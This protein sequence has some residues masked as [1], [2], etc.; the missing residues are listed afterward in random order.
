MG[1]PFAERDEVHQWTK[2]RTHWMMLDLT[3]NSKES[4]DT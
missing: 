4:P 2:R 1:D 3:G